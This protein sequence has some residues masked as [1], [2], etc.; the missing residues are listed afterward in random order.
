VTISTCNLFT[1][2]DTIIQ[3]G[4]NF[5]GGTS[6][7]DGNCVANGTQKGKQSTVV[8][9]NLPQ[10]YNFTVNASQG[11]QSGLYAVSVDCNGQNPRVFNPNG[12]SN[13]PSVAPFPFYSNYTVINC[14]DLKWLLN[15]LGGV[16]G[17]LASSSSSSSSLLGSLTGSSS[18][19]SS[20]IGTG[21]GYPYSSTGSGANMISGSPFISF[22]LGAV[23][24]VVA[25]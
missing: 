2:F 23:L 22:I 5:P 16:G 9:T 11:F 19:G 7:D 1:Q 18:T 17:G 6:N 3:V 24:F 8:L 25:W 4:G 15:N 20:L 10:G 21:T 13:T 14:V 12:S